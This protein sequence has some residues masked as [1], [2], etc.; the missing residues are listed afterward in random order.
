MT[1]FQYKTYLHIATT[2]MLDIMVVVSFFLFYEKIIIIENQHPEIQL[3]CKIIVSLQISN[4]NKY[5]TNF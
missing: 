5:E 1:T 2:V 4:Y 3:L